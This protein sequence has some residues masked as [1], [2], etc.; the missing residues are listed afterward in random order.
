[1]ATQTIRL[2]APLAAGSYTVNVQADGSNTNAFTGRALA[3]ES[4]ANFWKF[5]VTAATAGLYAYQILSG[6]SAVV[7]YGWFYSASDVDVTIQDSNSRDDALTYQRIGAPAGAS[8]AADIAAIKAD[9]VTL[10]GRITSTLFSGI[11]SL[12]NWLGALAGSGTSS[13]TLAEINATTGGATYV[14][15]TDSLEAVRDVGVS[16]DAIDAIVNGVSASLTAPGLAAAVAVQEGTYCTVSDVESRLTAYGV[17]WLVDV[18]T[19]DGSRQ[20]AETSL[21]SQAIDYCNTIID[22]YIQDF[23]RDIANRPAGNVWLR[24]RCV[25]LACVRV[26]TMGG[27]DVPAVLQT[28]ADRALDWLHRA[29]LRDVQIPALNYRSQILPATHRKTGTPT[30]VRM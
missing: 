16:Q 13:S 11:T 23:V 20:S 24:D 4:I 21:V 9:T 30:V 22:T 2:A 28:E 29:K 7:A 8:I 3:A 17:D 25:D 5:T 26:F 1:M 19:P 12:A 27:R 18:V 6:A 10:T 15:A 14:N